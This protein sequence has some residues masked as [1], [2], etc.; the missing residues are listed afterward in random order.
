MTPWTKD[1][2]TLV[3]RLWDEGLSASEIGA[4][5]DPRRS[6]NAVIGKVHRRLVWR[7]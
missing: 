3:I 4:R 1:E 2:I 6:R 7:H 5:L